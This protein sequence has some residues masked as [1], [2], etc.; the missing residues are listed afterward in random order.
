MRNCAAPARA[1]A[2]LSMCVL[3]VMLA[4]CRSTAPAA[5][6]SIASL[7]S[8]DDTDRLLDAT[9]GIEALGCSLVSRFGSGVLIDSGLVVTSA[10]T[11]AGATEILLHDRDG[12]V[13]PA[14]LTALDID[15]DLAI[16]EIDGPATAHSPLGF[17]E[18][19]AGESGWLLSW[20]S[21]GGP[22]LKP[23]EV[24]RR[25]RVTIE[26]IYVE[27]VVERKAIEIQG[28]VVVG[29][30]GAAVVGSD[31]TVIGVVYGASREDGS[32]FAVRS[33]SIEELMSEPEPR[34]VARCVP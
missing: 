16:V 9:F 21:S 13:V 24:T 27:N 29:D 20:S 6:S 18:A 5:P 19:V 25:I 12:V 33:E 32:G 4:A 3:A 7:D 34:T 22:R 15:H 1:F 17:G 28:D 30:S 31:G 14:T 8:I 2:G 11:V 23:V 10:H 26:D